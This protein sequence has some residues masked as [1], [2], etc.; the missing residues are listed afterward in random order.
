MKQREGCI[1]P[2]GT[3]RE[4]VIWKHGGSSRV[5]SVAGSLHDNPQHQ[6]ES[7]LVQKAVVS[8]LIA[9]TKTA[10]THERT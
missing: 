7:S 6:D 8:Y 4:V 10:V 1:E 5:V 2:N 9:T 3:T